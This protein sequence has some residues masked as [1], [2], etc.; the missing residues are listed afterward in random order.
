[1]MQTRMARVGPSPSNKEERKRKK[2]RKEKEIKQ[3]SPIDYRLD[4]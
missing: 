4:K 3:I 1:M 2:I